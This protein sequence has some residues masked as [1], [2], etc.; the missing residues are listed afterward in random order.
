MLN[1]FRRRPI[2]KSDISYRKVC[3]LLVVGMFLS[4]FM[5][6]LTGCRENSGD[7]PTTTTAEQEDNYSVSLAFPAANKV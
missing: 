3:L 4:F 6:L 2:S 1:Y 7:N 5:T